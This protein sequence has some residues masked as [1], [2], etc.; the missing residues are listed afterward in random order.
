MFKKALMLAAVAAL[1]VGVT[2]CITITSKTETT[3]SQ[4][5]VFITKD[6]GE[7]WVN[8]SNLMTTGIA[9]GSIAAAEIL[10]M[11]F[12]PADEQAIYLGTRQDGLIYTYNGGAGWNYAFNK[13]TVRAMAVDPSAHC[14][15]YVAV[16]NWLKKTTD[17]S[18]KWENVYYTGDAARLVTAISID[19]KSP[20]IIWLGLSSGEVLKS[21]DAGK[22]WTKKK[23]LSS[24]VAK[25]LISNFDSKVVY[26]AS[27]ETG[28]L[29]TTDAGETWQSLSAS[30][31][32][33][34]TNEIYYYRGLIEDG[35][36]AG[37]LYYASAVGLFK[38]TTGGQDWT[39]MNLVTPEDLANIYSI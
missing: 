12:D 37:V 35:K 22:S 18:R 38:T 10:I 11:E 17:C 27:L 14:T 32:D 33:L 8:S 20:K 6:Y 34:G 30:L 21:V 39:A 31:E 9:P 15:I 26:A 4:A 13:G 5:G 1:L 16:D 25:I 28:L 24:R 3:G 7:T 2:G 23:T 19:L 36:K 29:K